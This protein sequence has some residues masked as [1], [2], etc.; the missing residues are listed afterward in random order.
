MIWYVRF[1]YT[2]S[3]IL[4]YEWPAHEREKEREKSPFSLSNKRLTCSY[5][6]RINFKYGLTY[7]LILY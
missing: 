3:I 5:Q 6:R 2:I 4:V 7:F 1:I